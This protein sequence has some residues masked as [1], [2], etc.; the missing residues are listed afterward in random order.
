MTPDFQTEAG[1]RD[2]REEILETDMIHGIE[3]IHEIGW[4]HEIE[5][6]PEIEETQETE[7]ILGIAWT[8][9][10]G[11]TLGGIPGTEGIQEGILGADDIREL[12]V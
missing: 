6:I 4:I 9:G 5:W 1:I 2:P 8:R 12:S 3:W 10:T 11:W 7:W